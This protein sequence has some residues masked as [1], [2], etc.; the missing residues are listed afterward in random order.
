MDYHVSM[1]TIVELP[2]FIK[3]AGKIFSESL[4]ESLVNYLAAHPKAGVILEGT[5][6][7]RKFRWKREGTGKSGGA[8]VIYYYYNDNYPLFVIT[9]FKKGK[10][11][12]LSKEERNEL[13]KFVDILIK[14]YGVKT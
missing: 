5:G 4:R 8:R 3:Q 6:G 11:T 12:N 1:N 10:K 2:E 9:A 14:T 13:A 7:I